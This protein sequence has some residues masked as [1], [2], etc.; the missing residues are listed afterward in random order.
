MIDRRLILCA[1]VATLGGGFAASATPGVART[2][3]T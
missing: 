3:A 2:A 1:G